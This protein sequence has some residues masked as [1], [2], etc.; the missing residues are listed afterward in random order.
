MTNCGFF[1]T[2]VLVSLLLAGCGLR[3]MPSQPTPGGASPAAE[4]VVV[5]S[6]APQTSEELTEL[7][8]EIVANEVQPRD[9]ALA[10]YRW[11]GQ[12]IAYDTPALQSGQLPDQSAQATLLRKTAVCAGYANL[13]HALASAAGLQSEVVPGRSRDPGLETA[14]QFSPEESNHAWNAVKLEGDWW[15]LDPTWGAGYLDDGGKFVSQPND[16]WF[17]VAPEIF[18]YSHWPEDSQW[19]LLSEPI[20]RAEFDRLPDLKPEFFALGF[21]LE[22]QVTQP[23]TSSGESVL[24]VTAEKDNFVGGLLTRGRERLPSDF[25]LAQ[26]NGRSTELRVRFPAPGEYELY[27]MGR[28][29]GER[30]L[31]SVGRLQVNANG[32]ENEPFPE[33]FLSFHDREVEIL[34][35]T[36]KKLSAHRS[37]RFSYRVAGAESVYL[38]SGEDQVPFTRAGDIFTLDYQP[39]AGKVVVLAGFPGDGNKLQGLLKYQAD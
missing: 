22:D 33:T 34:N 8:R 14:L 6:R 27:L 21:Q 37:Q 36:Q 23:L 25:V 17:A 19:Q 28:R 10:I 5:P 1:I 4:F 15:L 12:N 35:G 2:G 32:S 38:Q 26:R 20:T 31:R 39:A 7:A 24:R 11:L 16:E 29:A 9:Q 13:F 18:V 30:T 3:P